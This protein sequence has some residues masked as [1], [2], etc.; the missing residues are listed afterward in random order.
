MLSF[1]KSIRRRRV[2]GGRDG[3]GCGGCGCGSEDGDD[4]QR[5][6][7]IMPQLKTGLKYCKVL[8]LPLFPYVTRTNGFGRKRINVGVLI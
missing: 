7:Q 3:C 4:K 1:V 2:G 5:K 6:I 8:W